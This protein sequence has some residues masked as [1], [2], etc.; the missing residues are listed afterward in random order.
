MTSGE[1]NLARTMRVL[2]AFHP[3]QG[4]QGCGDEVGAA[5]PHANGGGLQLHTPPAAPPAPQVSAVME[6]YLYGALPWFSGLERSAKSDQ[7]WGSS[8]PRLAATKRL[9]ENATREHS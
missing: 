9:D 3:N 6:V 2:W 1:Y 5:P 7:F 8:L 4:R